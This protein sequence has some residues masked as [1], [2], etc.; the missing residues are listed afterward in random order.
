MFWGLQLPSR[1]LG[2]ALDFQGGGSYLSVDEV[3]SDELRRFVRDVDFQ[4]LSS[5]TTEPTKS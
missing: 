5:G 4:E 1:L 2:P 3:S